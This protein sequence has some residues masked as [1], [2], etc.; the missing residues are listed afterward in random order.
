MD[1]LIEYRAA[2]KFLDDKLKTTE[3]EIALWVSGVG[4]LRLDA[5]IQVGTGRLILF[6]DN[7]HNP[8]KGDN[9]VSPLE[10]LYFKQDEL[11]QFVEQ[12]PKRFISFDALVER[13]LK[14]NENDISKTKNYIHRKHELMEY[15]PI[16]GVPD[17]INGEGFERGLF[18]LSVVEAVERE[19]A[20]TSCNAT[21]NSEAEYETINDTYYQIKS[22]TV[23]DDI[24]QFTTAEIVTLPV[25][26][27]LEESL[28]SLFDPVTTEALSKMFPTP[29]TDSTKKWK[30]WQY[31]AK[32][33]GLINSRVSNSMFN[34]YKAGMWFLT[35]KIE[36]WDLARVN[37][38]LGN[39]LP[40]RSLDEKHL[41]TGE[42]E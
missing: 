10:S 16:K 3:H 1:D 36:G 8:F 4:G 34:P 39:N 35:R 31:R 25:T 40:T 32:K 28:V 27:D 14:Y 9:Y 13:W 24:Q 26:I 12:S 5:Y 42:I 23:I 29:K 20:N 6:A 19:L 7:G 33:N 11:N 30:E 37:R 41:L 17:S 21:Q 38:V 15:H 18:S 2:K 22:L